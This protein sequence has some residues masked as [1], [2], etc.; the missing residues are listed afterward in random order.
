MSPVTVIKIIKR[1]REG[2]IDNALNE[3]QRP[4]APRTFDGKAKAKITALACSTPPEGTARWSLR[5]LADKAVELNIVEDISYWSIREIL[6]KT[7]LNR[8]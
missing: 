8:I 6:K 3:K 4:G 5:L 2:D 7:N 1:Y